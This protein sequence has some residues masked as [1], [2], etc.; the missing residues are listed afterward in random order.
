MGPQSVIGYTVTPHNIAGYGEGSQS[1]LLVKG[2]PYIL[3]FKESFPSG[4]YDT[5]W[6]RDDVTPAN[7]FRYNLGVSADNDNGSIYWI[8][9]DDSS[10]GQVNTAKI[11]ISE[12]AH[13]VLSFYYYKVKGFNGALYVDIDKE[14]KI[15]HNVFSLD[16]FG[17]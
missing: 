7:S 6:W 2:A 11:D 16:Y 5:L 8:P 4:N 17:K 12:A 15:E 13:P 9:S 1:H 3:P 14:M 10:Y